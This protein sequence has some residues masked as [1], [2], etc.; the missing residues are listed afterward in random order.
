MCIRDRD[1]EAQVWVIGRCAA[2]HGGGHTSFSF[3]STYLAEERNTLQV[4]AL[5]T[6]AC[7]RP[8]GKQSWKGRNFGCWYTPTTGIWQSV[9][10]TFT[11]VSYTHLDVYKRQ[12]WR[13]LH[14]G[15]LLGNASNPLRNRWLL[16]F[17]SLIHI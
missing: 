10:L 17:L 7:D 16:Y 2:T 12:A 8:R 15:V 14:G 3:D 9:W 5:D 4:K 13:R 11:S 6:L 1:Y